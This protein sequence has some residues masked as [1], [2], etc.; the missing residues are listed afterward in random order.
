AGFRSIELA[1]LRPRLRTRNPS[2]GLLHKLTQFHGKTKRSSINGSA[3]PG[4]SLPNSADI[5]LGASQSGKMSRGR[6]FPKRNR[7]I[8][9]VESW[10]EFGQFFSASKFFSP[11]IAIEN[12]YLAI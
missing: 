9:N 1:T 7:M 11:V 3:N 10:S 5:I 12:V 4:T 2:D 6:K 8:L